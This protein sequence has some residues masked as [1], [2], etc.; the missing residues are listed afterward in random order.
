MNCRVS[1]LAIALQLLI[2][3]ISKCSINPIS[4]SIVTH[5]RDNIYIK[6]NEIIFSKTFSS[7]DMS[8]ANPFA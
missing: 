7:S 8:N 2:V 4:P 3:T 1:E 5:T 6:L